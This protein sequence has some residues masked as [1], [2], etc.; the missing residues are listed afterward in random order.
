MAVLTE[1]DREDIWADLM[2]RVPEGQ[3]FPVDK[4]TFRALI[5]ACDQVISDN[6]GTLNQQI[7]ALNAQWNTLSLSMRNYVFTGVSNK[8]YGTGV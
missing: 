7:Q 8:R 1:Q 3:V 2:R 4:V 6:A 5:A